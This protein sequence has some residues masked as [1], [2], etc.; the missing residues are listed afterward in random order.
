M[1]IAYACSPISRIEYFKQ[2][3]EIVLLSMVCEMKLELYLKHFVAL[4]HSSV[5]KHVTKSDYSSLIHV[6]K[7][8][9]QWQLLKIFTI[10]LVQSAINVN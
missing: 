6:Y 5:I 8:K 7:S 3:T 1:I 9:L 10:S 2:N 4:W